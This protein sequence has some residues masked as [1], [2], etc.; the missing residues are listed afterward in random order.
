MRLRAIGAAVAAAAFAASLTFVLAGS[1]GAATVT[2]G[3]LGGSGSACAADVDFVQTGPTSLAVPSGNWTVSSWSTQAGQGVVGPSAGQ[4][5]LEMWRPTATPNAFMLVGIS[6]V[7]TTTVSGVNTFTLAS[8]I[9]VQGGDLLGLRNIT[10]NYGCATQPTSGTI[11]GNLD[12]TAPT[13]GSTV[14]FTVIGSTAILN[15]TATLQSVTPPTPPTTTPAP[16]VA[17]VAAFTG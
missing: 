3:Q 9:A 2:I 5:Q 12:P 14:T 15:V 4:L 7:V 1:V 11:A 10:H 8:P 6:P 13:P 16:V 17:P